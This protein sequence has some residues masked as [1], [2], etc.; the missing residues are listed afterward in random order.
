MNLPTLN[1]FWMSTLKWWSQSAI[2]LFVGF[3]NFVLLM[4]D[5]NFIVLNTHCGC[6]CN[7][8]EG[9]L[10]VSHFLREKI[11]GQ[12]FLFGFIFLILGI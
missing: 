9:I 4:Q 12:K 11:K 5:M 1:V 10:F 6:N 3:N 7:Y 2:R 8:A